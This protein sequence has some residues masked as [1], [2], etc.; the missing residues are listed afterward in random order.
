M[1]VGVSIDVRMSCMGVSKCDC[2][3]GHECEHEPECDYESESEC[4]CAAQCVQQGRGKGQHT[5][6]RAGPDAPL[7]AVLGSAGYGLHGGISLS[8]QC[9][10]RTTQPIYCN[11]QLN[12]AQAPSKRSS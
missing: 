11:R 7:E 6:P 4:V 2:A 12:T 5:C 8:L 10:L 1:S 9:Y 3:H